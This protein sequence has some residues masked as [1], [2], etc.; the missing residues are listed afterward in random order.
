MEI[1]ILFF[2]VVF[3]QKC[4]RLAV[5]QQAENKNIYCNAILAIFSSKKL[6]NDFER[7]GAYNFM[8]SI[9]QNQHIRT[10]C[11]RPCWLELHQTIGF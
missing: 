7:L 4:F 6:I 8:A 10:A 1:T 5:A 11:E 3:L 9:F 2:E